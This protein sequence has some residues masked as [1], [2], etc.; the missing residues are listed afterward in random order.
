MPVIE[1]QFQ[2]VVTSFHVAG[3]AKSVH[4]GGGIFL[5]GALVEGKFLQHGCWL[6]NESELFGR[7]EPKCSIVILRKL[8]KRIQHQKTQAPLMIAGS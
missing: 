6:E 2:S 1:A 3:R 5:L 4:T 8:E 7:V